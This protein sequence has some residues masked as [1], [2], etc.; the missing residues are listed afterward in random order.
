MS[1]GLKRVALLVGIAALSVTGIGLLVG[2]AAGFGALAGVS[3]AA[4]AIGMSFLTSLGIAGLSLGSM[5][6]PKSVD[7]TG[8]NSR[9]SP[10]VDIGALGAYVFGRTTVPDALTREEAGRDR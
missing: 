7:D 3:A 8:A 2:P 1:K 5:P 9:G 4:H 6:S 10:F